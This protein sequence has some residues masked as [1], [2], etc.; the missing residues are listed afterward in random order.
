MRC[1][2]ARPAGRVRVAARV[3]AVAEAQAAVQ[4]AA[5]SA[6]L[7]RAAC[8]I[9]FATG[10][11]IHPWIPHRCGRLLDLGTT[12]TTP[13]HSNTGTASAPFAADSVYRI[14][15]TDSSRPWGSCSFLFP[16]GLPFAA[17]PDFVAAT[18]GFA[19]SPLL[20]LQASFSSS[21]A[22]W[23]QRRARHRKSRALAKPPAKTSGFPAG[24][25]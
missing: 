2:A 16:G 5:C 8:P 3:A 4:Q 18:P 15:E 10:G 25:P 1:I 19:S 22:R 21:S 7:R 6:C 24:P 23:P 11:R 17:P 13:R 9:F 12:Y 20:F 14:V